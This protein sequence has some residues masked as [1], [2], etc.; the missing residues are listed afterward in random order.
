MY[1]HAIHSPYIKLIL[2]W[3]WRGIFLWWQLDNG[4]WQGKVACHT[5]VGCFYVLWVRVILKT[6][7]VR[8]S[9]WGTWR[10]GRKGKGYCV[11]KERDRRLKRELP[12]A[13]ISVLGHS[14]GTPKATWDR[15]RSCFIPPVGFLM[16]E[17]GRV[18]S[19]AS[20]ILYINKHFFFS[21]E[22]LSEEYI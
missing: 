8:L 15:S 1:I 9:F 17:T 14:W 5:L 2:Q 10:G 18:L 16:C 19:L 11:A 6:G 20:G 21:Y 7:V 3:V 12:F 4:M 22:N 13:L